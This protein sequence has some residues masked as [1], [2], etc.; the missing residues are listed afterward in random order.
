MRGH[1]VCFGSEIR[2]ILRIIIKTPSHLELWVHDSKVN[3][4]FRNNACTS[5]ESISGG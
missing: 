5:A 3:P 2:T 4:Y 1:N